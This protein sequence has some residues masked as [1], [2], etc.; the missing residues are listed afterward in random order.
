MITYQLLRARERGS[1]AHLSQE[2]GTPA[3]ALSPADSEFASPA[4][5]SGASQQAPGVTGE[6]SKS[7]GFP[8]EAASEPYQLPVAPFRGVRHPA[9]AGRAS[10]QATATSEPP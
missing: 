1:V 9:R 4:R 8:G 6:A 5:G 7:G 2:I 10:N 3:K